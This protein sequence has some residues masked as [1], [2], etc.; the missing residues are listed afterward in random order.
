MLKM[1]SETGVLKLAKKRWH[2]SIVQVNHLESKCFMTSV[3]GKRKK[4]RM[5]LYKY[6]K[7]PT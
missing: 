6:M 5:A 3:C 4:E 2:Y 7:Q 1:E